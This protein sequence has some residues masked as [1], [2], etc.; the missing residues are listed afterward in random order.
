MRVMIIKKMIMNL[1]LLKQK[2][3]KLPKKIG[4]KDLDNESKA[5]KTKKKL[6]Q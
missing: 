4:K 2:K 5:V 6:N 1:R 3:P